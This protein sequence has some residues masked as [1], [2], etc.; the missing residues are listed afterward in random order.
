MRPNVL[1]PK[2]A[3]GEVPDYFKVKVQGAR[4]VIMMEQSSASSFP[5]NWLV[6]S[7][8]DVT[9]SFCWCFRMGFVISDHIRLF[10]KGG[11]WHISKAYAT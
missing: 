10:A 5:V 8:H 9:F 4:F 1:M 7:Q 3:K 6:N 2:W 11:N